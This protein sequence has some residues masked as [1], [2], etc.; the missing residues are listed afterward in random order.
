MEIAL[1]SCTKKDLIRMYHGAPVSGFVSISV[2]F[3][4]F[5]NNF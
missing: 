4:K 2:C 5:V 3:N 1:A